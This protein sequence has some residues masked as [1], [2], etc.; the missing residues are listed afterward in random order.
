[1]TATVA[2]PGFPADGGRG[3]V[4]AAPLPPT[5]PRSPRVL[6]YDDEGGLAAAVA[7]VLDHH[8]PVEVTGCGESGELIRLLTERRWDVLVAGPGL[9]DRAGFKRLRIIR[10]ELPHLMVVL[11]AADA[12]ALDVQAVAR[13]GVVDLLR[14]PPTAPEL[15]EAL[16]RAIELGRAIAEAP[17]PA[18]PAEAAPAPSR[19]PVPHRGRIITV[20]SASGGCGK[21]FLATNLAWFLARRGGR[22]VCI[23]D[24][25]LQFGE[26]AAALRLHPAA[27]ILDLARHDDPAG[28]PAALAES[29]V[30]HE[31]GFSVLAAPGDPT[32]AATIR[33]DDI[34]RILEAAR[35][36]FDDVI[37]DT[38]PALTDGVM[39][40]YHRSDELFVMATL[41]IPSIRNLQVFLATLQRLEVPAETVRLVLNKAESG[42]GIEAHQLTR[43]FPQ[44]FAATL[45]YE[46]E[47][48]RSI[49]A[50]QPVLATAPDTAIAADLARCLHRLLPDGGPA[51]ADRAGRGASRFRMPGRRSKAGPG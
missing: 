41:D 36:S 12:D 40:A 43:L 44:G 46:R 33:P 7:S 45:P 30:V 16:D 5:R 10:E 48:H 8:G 6:V 9:D 32:E 26:V 49:N 28:L 35:A 37:V 24:L 17:E 22:R 29:R 14:Q 13:A 47:V 1:M 27:T 31:A 34:S 42:S 15:R 2:P 23:V 4:A 20:A 25:D 11:I 3:L 21:T 51:D 38:P 19:Q 39:A 50:G 18:A